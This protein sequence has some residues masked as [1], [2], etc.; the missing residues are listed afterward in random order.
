MGECCLAN[1]ILCF[2]PHVVLLRAVRANVVRPDLISFTKGQSTRVVGRMWR[3]G[4][5][6]V[7][8]RITVHGSLVEVLVCN[9][10][11]FLYRCSTVKYFPFSWF[12]PV[13]ICRSL[14]CSGIVDSCRWETGWLWESWAPSHWV[15]EA[16]RGRI[17]WVYFH[18]FQ[19]FREFPLP[20]LGSIKSGR[21]VGTSNQKMT[22]STV[23]RKVQWIW[24]WG[25]F[26]LIKLPVE[27]GWCWLQSFDAYVYEEPARRPWFN[28][29]TLSLEVIHL[30]W[31]NYCFGE[32]EGIF[33]WQID[34]EMERW[35][36]L[37]QASTLRS[38]LW[39]T[40]D[41]RTLE[42][43]KFLLPR[44]MYYMFLIHCWMLYA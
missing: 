17:R 27:D 4:V 1:S 11:L 28:H 2:F 7:W 16:S 24:S 44:Y 21:Q 22:N 13:G 32:K 18:L 10:F 43:W 29:M 20:L 19:N 12:L 40:V 30:S 8:D 33:F 36:S 39:R 38:G 3:E 14:A 6:E 15:P 31:W 34:F 9:L 26:L 5:L 35:L 25:P 42:G 23:P 37:R 41:S